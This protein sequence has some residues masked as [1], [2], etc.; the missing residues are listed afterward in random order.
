[1][2][3]SIWATIGI[4]S[5]LTNSTEHP[6]IEGILKPRKGASSFRKLGS[7]RE[8]KGGLGSPWGVLLYGSPLYKGPCRIPEHQVLGGR[9]RTI[10]K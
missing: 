10:L 5:G 8:P 4:L 7:L 1:M 9:S 3:L 6:S 2:E